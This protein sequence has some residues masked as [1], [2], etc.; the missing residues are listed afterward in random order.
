M[1]VERPTDEGAPKDGCLAWPEMAESEGFEPSSPAKGCQFSR[2]VY[3]TALPA[4]RRP[5]Y[6]FWGSHSSS[7]CYDAQHFSRS[8]T[9]RVCE[10]PC[11]HPYSFAK[12]SEQPRCH[13]PA[14]SSR[15]SQPKCDRQ[16]NPI[17][18]MYERTE[19]FH[20]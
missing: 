17:H 1:P 14:D 15:G 18:S 4:L 5:F 10:F 6:G 16:P 20:P 7:C 9:I 8:C 11:D 2:L 19:A 3:S 12:P 13:L